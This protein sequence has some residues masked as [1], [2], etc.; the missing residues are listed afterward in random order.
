MALIPPFSTQQMFAAMTYRWG[1]ALWALLAGGDGANSI[2][3][4]F[5]QISQ[6]FQ[7]FMQTLFFFGSKDA[8]S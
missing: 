8:I 3:S 5:A 2:G 1:L 7:D 4:K 6:G